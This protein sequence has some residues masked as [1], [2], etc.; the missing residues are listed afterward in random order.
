MT[1]VVN[2]RQLEIDRGASL[3]TLLAARRID[4]QTVVV[5]LN[6]EVVPR[7]RFAEIELQDGDE[8]E[9]VRFVGGG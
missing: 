3:A 9:V 4:A 1:V 8:L 5:E 2:G 7:E 6:R